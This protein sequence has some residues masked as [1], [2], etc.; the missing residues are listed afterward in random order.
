MFVSWLAPKFPINNVA[1]YHIKARWLVDSIPEGKYTEIYA[2]KL[3]FLT[4]SVPDYVSNSTILM[5][6]AA[7]DGLSEKPNKHISKRSPRL[8]VDMRKMQ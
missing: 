3:P 2:G 5:D 8:T 6:K 7:G 4:F 1:E